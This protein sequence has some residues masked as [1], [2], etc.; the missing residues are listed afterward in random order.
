M[1]RTSD[2]RSPDTDKPS[3]H[4]VVGTWVLVC[5]FFLPYIYGDFLRVDHFVLWGFTLFYLWPGL[6]VRGKLSPFE[7]KFL[8]V[9]ILITL[10]A[11]VRV[12]AS[13]ERFLTGTQMVQQVSY[14]LNGVCIF[15]AL[16]RLL[17]PARVSLLEAFLWVSVAVNCYGVYQSQYA[18][19]DLVRRM[20]DIYGG[21]RDDSYE[22]EGMFTIAALSVLGGQRFTSIFSGMHSYGIFNLLVIGI[23]VGALGDSAFSRKK[24]AAAA[25]AL[26]VWGGFLSTSKTFVFGAMIAVFCAFFMTRH[27]KKAYV[28]FAFLVTG[29]LLAF[30]ALRDELRVLD[31]IGSLIETGNLGAVFSERFGSQGYLTTDVWDVTFAPFTLLFGL[32]E[33]AGMYRY[34]DFQFRQVLLLGGFIFF[35]LYYY[36]IWMTFKISFVQRYRSPYAAPLFGGGMAF[37]GGGMGIAVHYQARIIPLW[38][39]LLLTLLSEQATDEAQRVAF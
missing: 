6:S 29:A 38:I 37:L 35:L 14:F 7:K 16:K 13:S 39:I 5:S 27:T 24:L 11:A 22:Y 12:Y 17:V 9:A 21:M 1:Y 19:S 31:D 34:S 36:A 28:L 20:L 2:A 18:D 15:L 4:Q 25:L 3:W 30:T 33:Q 10:F 23:A 32:G 26:G 8:N